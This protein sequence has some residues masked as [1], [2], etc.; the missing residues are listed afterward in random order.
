MRRSIPIQGKRR[1]FENQSISLRGE[2]YCV[3]LS[4]LADF[5]YVAEGI[6]ILFQ[7][8]GL[9]NIRIEDQ[10]HIVFR[11]QCAQMSWLQGLLDRV[12]NVGF[13]RNNAKAVLSRRFVYRILADD[14]F[15]ESR[16]L[17]NDLFIKQIAVSAGTDSRQYQLFAVC[18]VD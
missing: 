9:W 8:F 17:S 18:C 5:S 4:L 10:D 2:T 12:Q 14:L 11:C 16:Q 1:D 7:D 13:A 15:I 3:A 6:K